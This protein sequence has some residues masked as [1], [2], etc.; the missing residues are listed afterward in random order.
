MFKIRLSKT[1]E[2]IPYAKSSATLLN[3]AMFCCKTE[4]DEKHIGRGPSRECDFQAAQ[5]KQ[6]F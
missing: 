2:G 3:G 4:V 5:C 1:G 6:D